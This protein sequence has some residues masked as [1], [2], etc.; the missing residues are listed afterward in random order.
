VNPGRSSVEIVRELVDAWNSH[1]IERIAAFF[2][3]DF[4]NWQLPIPTVRGLDAY[5]DH[6]RHWFAAYPDLRMEIVTLFADGDSVCLETRGVGTSSAP[7]FGGAG[8]SASN[9]NRALDILELRDGK[10][11]RERGYWDFS[12]FTGSAS[13]LAGQ[14]DLRDAPRPEREAKGLVP[15]G[16]L[17]YLEFFRRLP[18]VPLNE[19]HRVASTSFAEWSRLYPQDELLANLGRTWRMG[20]YPYILGW[21]CRGIERWDEWNEIFGSGDVDDLEHP[22]LDVMATDAAGFYRELLPSRPALDGAAYYLETFA[23]WSGAADAYRR[24]AE[25]HG[26]ELVLLLERVGRLA[27][28]PGGLALLAL[29]AL[30]AAARL[31]GDVPS[32]V[33]EI[34]VYAP[35]GREVL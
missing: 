32:A 13:P 11:W 33:A 23:P 28:E 25:E 1:D 8:D 22:I 34:G 26:A 2:H 20:P 14:P 5:R 6:L 31:Q 18:D 21:G 3:D 4:E 12:L 24:R 10:V 19:F 15:E 17:C 35:T 16:R 27:P 30:S 7:F 29:D 9:E